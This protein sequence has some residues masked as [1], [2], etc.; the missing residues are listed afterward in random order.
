MT[1]LS[2][3]Q[4]QGVDFGFI[5]PV[6]TFAWSFEEGEYPSYLNIALMNLNIWKSVHEIYS[7]LDETWKQSVLEKIAIKTYKPIREPTKQYWIQARMYPEIW[8][9]ESDTK[10]YTVNGE[11]LITDSES[12]VDVYNDCIYSNTITNPANYEYELTEITNINHN[13]ICVDEV[14]FYDN[15]NKWKN[16]DNIYAKFEEIGMNK[17]NVFSPTVPRT[18]WRISRITNNGY[19][20]FKLNY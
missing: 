14:C 2:D 7:K 5:V 20:Y 4:A 17:F 11:K 13:L 15:Y 12:T 18:A 3:V 19:P 9:I 10:F 8:F 6:P 1:E 16:I